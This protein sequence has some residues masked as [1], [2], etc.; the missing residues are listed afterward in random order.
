[1]LHS[2]AVHTQTTSKKCCQSIQS[3][4]I[5]EHLY[6]FSVAMPTHLLRLRA[7]QVGQLVA[8]P[9]LR[10]QQAPRIV[11]VCLVLGRLLERLLHHMRHIGQLIFQR[12][13]AVVELEPSHLMYRSHQARPHTHSHMLTNTHT[14]KQSPIAITKMYT[15]FY[16]TLRWPT[17]VCSLVWH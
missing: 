13:E 9:L 4:N 5:S 7:A 2:A 10:L 1:M 6:R 11:L 15:Q 14:H 17:P 12:A 16:R 8:A 3:H